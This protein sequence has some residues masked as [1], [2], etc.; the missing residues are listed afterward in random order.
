MLTFLESYCCIIFILA[1]M[2]RKTS[3]PINTCNGRFVLKWFT[4]VKML[5]LI[6]CI[7]SVNW[8]VKNTN[9]KAKS[10]GMIKP[11]N[12]MM[13]SLKFLSRRSDETEIRNA[14]K[15]TMRIK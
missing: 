2:V 14:G 1:I 10:T 4:G 8:S 5:L 7:A 6:T 11:I 12:R 13:Y 9:V 3:T 15:I